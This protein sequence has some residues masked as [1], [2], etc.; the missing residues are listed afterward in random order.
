MMDIRI[1]WKYLA[2]LPLLLFPSL[3]IPSGSSAYQTGSGE[4]FCG[5]SRQRQLNAIAKDRYLESRTR[6]LERLGR[7]PL[8]QVEKPSAAS[9]T[10]DVAVIEDDG[11]VISDVNQFD[12]G[13][14]S[15][16]F[17]PAGAGSYRAVASDSSY[18]STTGTTL[19]LKDD[20]TAEVQLGFPLTFYGKTYTRVELNS[21]G[22]LTFVQG[23]AA[24]TDRDLARFVSGPPR[25]AP[26]FADLNPQAGGKISYRS[27]ADG[28]MF[29]WDA[30][31]DFDSTLNRNS[32]NVRLFT[33]GNIEFSYGTIVSP[34]A[35]VGIAPG[36]S[37]GAINAVDFTA[38]LPT[39]SLSGALVEVFSNSTLFS[40]AALSRLFFK[41]HPDDFDQLV[42][43]FAFSLTPVQGAFA[44]EM[45]IKN[46]IEGL[47]LELNDDT[48]TYGSN[49]RLRSFV[50][51]GSLDGPTRFPTDP[52][53]NFFRTYNT[54]Q[55]VAHEVA[56]RWLAHPR[57]GA[58]QT[59]DLIHTS[60]KA[61]W[62]FF[63]NADASVMEGNKL[64]DRGAD[65]GDLRF[66][67][68]EATNK[69]SALDKYLMGY[70]RKE[71]VPPMFF[72]QNP[73]GIFQTSDSLPS[74]G[75]IFGGTRK[76]FTVDDVVTANG[77][78]VPSVLQS[79]KVY[80]QAFILLTRHGQQ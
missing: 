25:I 46:E 72:V 75:V 59:L 37:I 16:R 7:R 27:M 44:Y 21:D 45:N 67:T 4:S 5:T 6:L 43:F 24:S 55:V 36:G 11:T 76:D 10:G 51:M 56:H 47:G 80:R 14:R 18:D 1:R 79:P 71:D 49:G 64:E 60:D 39:S 48:Q 63:L 8:S 9:D 77:S 3:A 58:N 54:L 65:K 20:D 2:L 61:H 15:F 53:A 68:T 12:L 19:A 62:S 34:A 52:T 26:F 73:T 66:M 28:M 78:R 30:V 31:P 33:N 23:D 17:E 70:A 42:A 41:T 40:E 74:L 32:F 38:G 35:V 57:F 69:Y 13:S 22:N 29:T 50:M